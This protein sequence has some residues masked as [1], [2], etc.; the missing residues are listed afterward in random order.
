MSD[1]LLVFNGIEGASGAYLQERIWSDPELMSR[2]SYQA[3]FP[4][5]DKPGMLIEL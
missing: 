1:E 5:R 3:L 2:H 4:P